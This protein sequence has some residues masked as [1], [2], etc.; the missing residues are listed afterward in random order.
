MFQVSDKCCNQ[1]LFSPNKI[2]SDKRRDNLLKEICKEQTYFV[3]HKATIAGKET[4]CRGFYESLGHHS[5]MIR[6]AERLSAVE[7]VSVES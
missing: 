2:V 3:C 6:I 5:Q 4:C 7:F 1:C